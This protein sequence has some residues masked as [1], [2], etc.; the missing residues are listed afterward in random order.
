MVGNFYTKYEG[1]ATSE[2]F[3]FYKSL[4]QEKPECSVLR[5]QLI[6]KVFWLLFNGE[7]KKSHKESG[8]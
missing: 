8:A 4:Q 2:Y 1:K 3:N 6:K 5:S 7:D